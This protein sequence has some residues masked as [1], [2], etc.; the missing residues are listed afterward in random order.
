[1]SLGHTHPQAAQR[2]FLGIQTTVFLVHTIFFKIDNFK[3]SQ[4]NSILG[5]IQAVL[6]SFRDWQFMANLLSSTVAIHRHTHT[7][8]HTDTHTHADLGLF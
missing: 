6:P 4:E 7:H 2:H 5:P 3:H 1:M 8:T